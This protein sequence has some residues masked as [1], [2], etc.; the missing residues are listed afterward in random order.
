MNN[1][2]NEQNLWYYYY[3]FTIFHPKQKSPVLTN[4]LEL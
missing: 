2:E 4:G 3:S 1:T